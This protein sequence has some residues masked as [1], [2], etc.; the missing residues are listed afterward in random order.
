MTRR[1]AEEPEPCAQTVDCRPDGSVLPV[2][3]CVCVTDKLSF[4]NTETKS[5][6]VKL[7]R[8]SAEIRSAYLRLSVA[9]RLDSENSPDTNEIS[10]HT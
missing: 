3:S 10:P 7:N 6:E 1:A 4:I 9:K 2:M 5:S 8:H